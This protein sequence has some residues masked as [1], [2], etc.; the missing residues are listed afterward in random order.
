MSESLTQEHTV[1]ETDSE[2][3]VLTF[4][5]RMLQWPNP[6]EYVN[7]MYGSHPGDGNV[8]YFQIIFAATRGPGVDV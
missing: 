4:K 8:D 7:N 2:E 5:K 6:V 3:A 1:Q